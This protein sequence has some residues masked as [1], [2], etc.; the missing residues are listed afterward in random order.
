MIKQY[1]T[2]ALTLSG[3]REEFYTYLDGGNSDI[4]KGVSWVDESNH[5]DGFAMYYDTAKT[6][7]IGYAMNNEWTHLPWKTNF[8]DNRN[9]PLFVFPYNDTSQINTSHGSGMSESTSF[10][11]CRFI[12][13]ECAFCFMLFTSA[14]GAQYRRPYIWFVTKNKGAAI[15]Y[16]YTSSGEINRH[17]FAFKNDSTHCNMNDTP[18]FDTVLTCFAP[19]CGT[20]QTESNNQLMYTPFTSTALYPCIIDSEIGRYVTDGFFAI[21]EFYEEVN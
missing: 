14:S 7:L 3:I 5:T 9:T 15:S 21:P 2:T 20:S 1:S 8:T 16:A 4:I 19:L 12:E 17:Y 13:T 18:T 11:S 6:D 10:N